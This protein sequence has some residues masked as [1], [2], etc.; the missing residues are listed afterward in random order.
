MSNAFK[1]LVTFYVFDNS[2]KIE[3]AMGNDIFYI[4]KKAYQKTVDACKQA[5]YTTRCDNE[6]ILQNEGKQ[7]Q[8][9]A[10]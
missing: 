9:I 3:V 1:K 10:A 4:A 8:A 5:G 2:D 7:E 6:Y